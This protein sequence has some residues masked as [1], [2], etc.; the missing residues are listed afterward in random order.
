MRLTAMTD[1]ALRLMMYVA[2]RPERLCT[3]A[4]IAQVHGISEAH[5]MKVTHQLGLQGWI[6]TVRGKGGGMR[7]SRR[8]Q[9]V[10]LGELVRGVEPN[11]RLVECFDTGSTCP[12]TG[13]CG[14]AGILDGALQRFLAHLDGFTLA[15]ALEATGAT[16]GGSQPVRVHRRALA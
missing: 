3:I 5:L 13:R 9:D 4:E 11:F 2:Q 6:E 1:Y 8:P 14:L 7:L 12:L 15:D 16:L 10:N